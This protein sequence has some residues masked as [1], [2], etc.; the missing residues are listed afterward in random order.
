MAAPIGSKRALGVSASGLEELLGEQLQKTAKI[1]RE[2]WIQ[3]KKALL[4]DVYLC[5]PF[6]NELGFLTFLELSALEKNKEVQYVVS[7]L[8]KA[9]SFLDDLSQ[10]N[11]SSKAKIAIDDETI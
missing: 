2:D 6:D 5:H 11:E 3:H 9:R 1:S 4:D 10:K 7:I 8:P